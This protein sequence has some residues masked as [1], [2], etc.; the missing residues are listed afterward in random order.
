MRTETLVLAPTPILRYGL[1]LPQIMLRVNLL[2]ALPALGGVVVYGLP[3]L[4]LLMACITGSILAEFF[5]K[6]LLGNRQRVLDGSALLSGLILA[7]LLPPGLSPWW[8]LG[9]AFI[10]FLLSRELFG[11]IGRNPLNPAVT[12]RLLISL[13]LAPQLAAARLAPFWWREGGFFT[14]PTAAMRV[15]QTPLEV[16][17]HCAGILEQTLRGQLPIDLPA[18]WPGGDVLSVMHYAQDLLQTW[19]PLEL[20]WPSHAGLLGCTS[21][22]LLLPGMFWLSANRVLDWR[23]PLPAL[24]LLLLGGVVTLQT[25]LSTWFWAVLSLRGTLLLMLIFF[26]AADPVT[27]PLSQRGKLI[28][29]LLLGLF[30]LPSLLYSDQEVAPLLALLLV[31]LLT[32]WMDRCTQPGG[33]R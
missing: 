5:L 10:G 26:L 19:T 16:A 6:A 3:A 23:I 7:L 13:A 15:L 30:L 2:L 32:P 22:V 33:P 28:Y 31:N 14:W 1:S 11:G 18:G 20:V 8:A 12:V 21:L 17:G 25:N 27:S 24:G 29:S 9:S 4:L